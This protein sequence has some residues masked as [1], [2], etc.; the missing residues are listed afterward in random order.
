[1]FLRSP[2]AKSN[3]DRG[4]GSVGRGGPCGTCGECRKA[5]AAGL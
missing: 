3:L 4:S 2:G 5:R 1:M